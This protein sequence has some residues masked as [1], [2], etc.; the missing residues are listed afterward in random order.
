[1]STAR[2]VV[3]NSA[4]VFSA[5][6]VTRMSSALLL[7]LV[8]RLRQPEAAGVFTLAISYTLLLEAVSQLG[9]DQLVIRDVA[10]E[11]NRA[12][13]VFSHLMSLRLVLLAAILSGF[14]LVTSLG[15]FYSDEIR[16][17]LIVMAFTALPDVAV[18]MCQAVFVAIDRLVWPSLVSVGAGALRLGLGIAVLVTGGTLAGMALAMLAASTAQMILNVVLVRRQ[19]VRLRLTFAGLQWRATLSQAL[20]FGMIQMLVAVESY[21]GGVL[22]SAAVPEAI[23]GYYGVANSLMA[24]LVL[25]PNAIQVAVFPKMTAAY[26]VSYERLTAFYTRI[27]RYLAALGGAV[28]ISLLIVADTLTVTLYRSAFR[29]SALLL[30]ILGGTLFVYFLNVPS[31]R[32]MIVLG[33]QRRIA[34]MLAISVTFNVALTLVS[35]PMLGVVAVPL[36]RVVSMSLLFV[37]NHLYVSRFI[38][39]PLLHEVLWRPLAGA[40]AAVVFVMALGDSPVWLRLGVVLIGYVGAIILLGG[41]PL[42]EW[43]YLRSALFGRSVDDRARIDS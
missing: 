22:L 20:P 41:L 15:R 4:L 42:D 10:R 28:V 39:S 29:P 11:S 34:E 26:A 17:V 19:G 37:M 5:N 43:R 14:A 31:V 27:Y 35:I 9:L 16:T 40:A 3:R 23:L 38:D 1:M 13:T 32:A 18:D 24:A 7:L 21:I 6:L 30:Q 25:I 8:A 36:A 2:S 12:P 33:R